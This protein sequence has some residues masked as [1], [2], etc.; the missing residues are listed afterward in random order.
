MYAM[1][2][3]RQEETP[4]GFPAYSTLP[5]EVGSSIGINIYAHNPTSPS[6]IIQDK[7]KSILDS[8]KS[9]QLP[10]H[11]KHYNTLLSNLTPPSQLRKRYL[12]FLFAY[13]GSTNL[14]ICVSLF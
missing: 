12:F 14:V 8:Y 7:P 5:L 6:R 13:I 1:K 2:D 9:I 3:S 10:F 11:H 4:A